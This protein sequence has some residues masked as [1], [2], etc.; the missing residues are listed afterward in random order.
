M[1][2]HNLRTRCVLLRKERK[3]S[4]QFTSSNKGLREKEENQAMI[5]KVVKI[6]PC[7]PSSAVTRYGREFTA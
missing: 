3:I 2:R 4:R 6:N 7:K 1:P 5:I